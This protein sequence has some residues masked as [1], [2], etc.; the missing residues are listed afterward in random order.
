MDERDMEQEIQNR[1]RKGWGIERKKIV[2]ELLFLCL[3]KPVT[4]NPKACRANKALSVQFFY[5]AIINDCSIA[6]G[7]E[8]PHK[9]WMCRLLRNVR[10]TSRQISTTASSAT[11]RRC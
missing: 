10:Q 9:F 2:L 1:R 3:D 8:N 7:S 11:Y 5:R 6:V 4:R